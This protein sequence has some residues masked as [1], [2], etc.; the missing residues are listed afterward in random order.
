MGVCQEDLN[1]VCGGR[2]VLS[3]AYVY[4][5]KRPSQYIPYY[6]VFAPLIQYQVSPGQ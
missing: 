3:P 6:G 5:V 4:G 1:V 2:L